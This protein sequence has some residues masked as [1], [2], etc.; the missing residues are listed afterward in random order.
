[1]KAKNL[2]PYLIYLLGLV[3]LLVTVQE[4]KQT[5]S[6]RPLQRHLVKTTPSLSKV[7]IESLS[8]DRAN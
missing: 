6:A 5:L 1:M 8:A 4:P 7:V 3:A 2:I